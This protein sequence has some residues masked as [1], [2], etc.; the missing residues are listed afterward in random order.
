MIDALGAPQSV[1]VLGGGSDIALATLRRWAGAGRLERVV[2]AGRPGPRRDAAADRV[3]GWAPDAAVE[4]VDFDAARPDTHA[5]AL[6]PVFAGPVDVVLLA[7]GVL[8]D[9]PTLPDPVAAAAVVTTNFTGAVSALTVVAGHLRAAGHGRVVVLSSVAGERVRR[10]N[11]LYGASKAG[12][13]GFAT[14]LGEDLRGSGVEVLIVRPGF[15]R[16]SMTDGLEPAPLAVDPDDVAR[17]VVRR[18]PGP[19]GVVWVPGTLR[20]VMSVLRHVPTPVF[21]RLPL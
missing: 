21:R 13:D 18:T 4:V 8:P 5:A 15:V 20:A 11:Y 7:F 16:S 19:G 12:L 3:R 17:V 10:S 6:D 2:L 9:G 14:G 1:L